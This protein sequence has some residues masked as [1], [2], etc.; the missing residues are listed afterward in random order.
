MKNVENSKLQRDVLLVQMPYAWM[1]PALGPSLLKADLTKRGISSRIEYGLHRF[2]RF[3]GTDNYTQLT[4]LISYLRCGWEVL[5][6]KF[7]GFQP[8]IGFQELLE[9]SRQEADVMPDSGCFNGQYFEPLLSLWP[10]LCE[11]VDRYLDLEVEEVLRWNPRIVGCSVMNQQRNA[12]LALLKRIKERRPEI[13]TILGGASFS[14]ESGMQ[15][16]RHAPYLDYVFSGEGDIVFAE[17]CELLLQNKREQLHR[18]HPWFLHPGGT[19]A[20]YAIQNLDDSSIPDFTE[21]YE[22]L[23]LEPRIES[24]EKVARRSLTLEASRGCWWGEKHRCRFCGMHYGPES[25]CFREKSPERVWQEIMFLS[26][27]YD[28]KYFQLTDCIMSPR[29]IASLPEVC[30]EE[31]RHLNIFAECK[32]NLTE[33]EI[34]RLGENGFVRLQPG[35]EALQDDLLKLMNK[36]CNTIQQIY[37]LRNARKYG[38][39]ASW[40]ILHTFPGEQLAW[41]DEMLELIPHLYHLQP[42]VSVI[43]MAIA[44]DNEFFQHPEEFHVGRLEIQICDRA[45]GP[46]DDEFLWKTSNYFNAPDIPVSPE[47][48]RR[49]LKAQSDWKD[50]FYHGAHLFYEKR[51]DTMLVRDARDRNN[52]R[53]FRLSG[54]EEAVLEGAMEPASVEKLIERFADQ[55]EAQAIRDAVHQLCED[56]LLYRKENHVI[57]LPVP[58]T[59]KKYVE[60][61]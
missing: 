26:K 34:R 2:I 5:F 29:F 57:S 52:I 8:E 13:I 25:V 18:E 51:G 11:Q 55:Y 23:N 33:D 31:R 1:S 43:R 22:S 10:A 59:A 46:A 53:N 3:L 12:S 30:P 42:P 17:G 14:G 32:S 45:S 48:I 38:V 6:A 61:I 56:H 16:F 15:Y 24:F 41:Y 49:L 35:I 40:N 4:R 50:A 27:K 60:I 37:F 39:I 36:G 7:A 21:Y 47:H 44:R 28:Q 20:V 54:A 9:L 58:S 19:P